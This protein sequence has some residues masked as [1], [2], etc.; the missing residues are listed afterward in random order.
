[1]REHSDI[2]IA[3]GDHTIAKVGHYDDMKHGSIQHNSFIEE[4]NQNRTPT[5]G[6]VGEEDTARS[7]SN[8]KLSKRILLEETRSKDHI[9]NKIASLSSVLDKENFFD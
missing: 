6:L 3:T 8:M 9:S 7:N 1:M 4:P 5:K 2:Q